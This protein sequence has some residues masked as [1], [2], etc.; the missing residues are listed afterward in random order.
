[1]PIKTFFADGVT[2]MFDSDAVAG[3]ICLG[4]VFIAAGTSW[5]KSWPW[6]AGATVRVTDVSGSAVELTG[7]SITVSN[8]PYPSVSVGAAAHDHKILLWATGTPTITDVPGMQAMSS[9]GTVALHPSGRGLNYLGKATYSELIPGYI[10]GG[11]E[12]APGFWKVLAPAAFTSGVTP[13]PVIDLGGGYYTAGTIMHWDSGAGRWYGYVS[14]YASLPTEANAASLTAQ[15]PDVYC[16]G[17]LAAPASGVATCAVYDDDGTLAFDLLAG[18]LLASLAVRSYSSGTTSQSAPSATKLGFF[19][20][21]CYW[22]VYGTLDSVLHGQETG[23]WRLA[24]G[25]LTR[26]LGLSQLVNDG[27][28][29][30]SDY[31]T[32]TRL[33]TTVELFE[34][35]S[36]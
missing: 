10:G 32:V 28:P 24:G 35:G 8:S 29:S 20:D 14:A 4:V 33:A 13:V 30:D 25:N 6:L 31:A 16:F 26:S 27:I 36:Y 23:F 5:S 18:P 17:R 3:G 2:T 9:G 11:G 15:Q 21:P 19:G 34:L 22:Q 12:R 1:M 7:V